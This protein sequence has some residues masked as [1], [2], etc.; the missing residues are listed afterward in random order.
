MDKLALLKSRM[1]KIEVKS[2]DEFIQEK[3]GK[4]VEATVAETVKPVEKEVVVVS[5][6]DLK[7]E[8]ENATV[9]LADAS[10]SGTSLGK[11]KENMH[12]SEFSSIALNRA[13]LEY[14]YAMKDGKMVVA[15]RMV[16]DL[17]LLGEMLK[18]LEFTGDEEAKKMIARLRSLGVTG[19]KVYKR[20][21]TQ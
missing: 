19:E 8:I 2:P 1:N 11:F 5:K 13:K 16:E 18:H 14:E 3:L 17:F 4:V 7:V 6:D 12:L 15:A 20:K 9:D 21:N 10:L